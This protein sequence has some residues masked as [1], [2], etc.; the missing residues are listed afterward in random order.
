MG[1]SIFAWV[2]PML[3]RVH[4][5]GVGDAGFSYADR[6]N[7]VSFSYLPQAC[8]AVQQRSMTCPADH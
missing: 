5:L 3:T 7:N 2:V 1:Y 8:P 4:G 6:K